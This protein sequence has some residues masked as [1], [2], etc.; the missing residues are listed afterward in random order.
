MDGVSSVGPSATGAQLQAV[1]QVLQS[2][3]EVQQQSM[4]QLLNAMGVGQN[5]DIEA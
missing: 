3:L 5:I 4:A 1:L 2:A